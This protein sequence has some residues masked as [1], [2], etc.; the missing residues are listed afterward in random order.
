ML[1]WCVCRVCG[2]LVSSNRK[3]KLT[4]DCRLNMP[5]STNIMISKLLLGICTVPY[6]VKKKCWPDGSPILSQ[7]V[8]YPIQVNADHIDTK[9]KSDSVALHEKQP[10]RSQ[11]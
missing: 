7:L 2:F 10:H 8:T 11:R 6:C 3:T 5:D 9:F 4:S 1:L